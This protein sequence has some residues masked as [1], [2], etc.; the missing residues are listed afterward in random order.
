MRTFDWVT[1]QM[2]IHEVT[3]VVGNDH[4]TAQRVR[5]FAFPETAPLAAASVSGVSRPS[6]HAGVR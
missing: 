1:G 3:G 5:T 2:R 4:I 6:G